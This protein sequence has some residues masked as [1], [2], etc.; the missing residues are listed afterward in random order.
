MIISFSWQLQQYIFL[1]LIWYDTNSWYKFQQYSY[2]VVFG[3]ILGPEKIS[4]ASTKNSFHKFSD[5]IQP[6]NLGEKKIQILVEN[7]VL[8]LNPPARGFTLNVELMQPEE[9]G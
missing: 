4:G 7:L 2:H 6:E 5:F 8:Q 1:W 3:Y 9:V